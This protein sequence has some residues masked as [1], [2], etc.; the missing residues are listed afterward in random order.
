M[1][2]GSGN[3]SATSQAISDFQDHNTD[4]K[5]AVGVTYGFDPAQGGMFFPARIELVFNRAIQDFSSPSSSTTT[6][7]LLRLESSTH[8]LLFLVYRPLSRPP[9]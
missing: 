9:P 8:Y 6:A 5:A 2:S 1:I 7:R 3:I 4:P